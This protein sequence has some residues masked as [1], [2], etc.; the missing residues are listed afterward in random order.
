MNRF[1]Q[2]HE[3]I[4][5]VK[6]SGIYYL[7]AQ[8]CCFLLSY[9]SLSA[10]NYVIRI[11]LCAIHVILSV[12]WNNEETLWQEANMRDMKNTYKIL[13]LKAW[14]QDHL[15]DLCIYKM[16]TLKLIVRKHHGIVEWVQGWVIVT[17]W[18]WFRFPN[19]RYLL[20]QMNNCQLLK[21]L[22]YELVI[23]IRFSH[24]ILKNL[25][26]CLKAL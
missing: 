4:V 6:D 11:T 9:I 16:L 15:G 8:V 25:Q 1:F 5:T 13:F 26:K 18:W 12:W 2:L 22:Q 14:W 7:Y 19:I 24:I 21:M 17:Q 10:C 23:N 3:G 20:D